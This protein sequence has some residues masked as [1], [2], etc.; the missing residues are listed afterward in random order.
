V[1]EERR[2]RWCRFFRGGGELNGFSVLVKGEKDTPTEI[3][4]ERHVKDDINNGVIDI[5]NGV[6][7]I[8]STEFQIYPVKSS[9][10]INTHGRIVLVDEALSFYI[11]T[12]FASSLPSERHI[13]N[14]V[15][16]W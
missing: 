1:V 12:G 14:T 2:W 15:V 5:K 3:V 4:V 6:I 10:T 16:S 11:H 9:V 8:Y 13:R 7:G